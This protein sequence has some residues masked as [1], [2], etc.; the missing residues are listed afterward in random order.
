M[1]M[2]ASPE[3]TDAS[4]DRRA[5]APSEPVSSVTRVAWSAESSSPARPIGPRRSAT[6]YRVRKRVGWRLE[7]VQCH[8]DATRDHPRRYRGG[9]RIYRDQRAGELVDLGAVLVVEDH[10][11]RPVELPLAA[12]LGHLAGEQ[13][14]PA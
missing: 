1:T 12:E 8:P 5:A 3:A 10:V 14:P 11:V 6:A 4:V 7:G 2:P 9:G 13:P